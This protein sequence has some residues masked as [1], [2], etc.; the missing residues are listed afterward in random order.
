MA[1]T[2]VEPF[3]LFLGKKLRIT[4]VTECCGPDMAG[5]YVVTDGFVSIQLSAEVESGAE[6]ITR[7]ADGS[8]CVN[9]RMSDA[10]KRFTLVITL[11]EVDACVYSLISNAVPYEDAEGNIIGFTVPEGDITTKF[12][13][14]L[15]TGLAGVACEEGVEEASGYLLLPCV[16]GGTLGDLTIDGENAVTFTINGAFTKGGNGW[17]VGPWDDVTPDGP[18]PTPLDPGDHLL[19]IKENVAPPENTDGCVDMTDGSVSV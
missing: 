17:G 10:F 16:V 14:E 1:T 18:L 11:C 15:W 7:K 12:A 4:Q 13:L 5:Q 6:I 19:L 9:E 2:V 8:L 3:N